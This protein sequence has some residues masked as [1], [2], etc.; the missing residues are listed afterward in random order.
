[1]HIKVRGTQVAFQARRNPGMDLKR[2]AHSYPLGECVLKVSK[3]TACFAN[4]PREGE[5]SHVYK[6][7]QK[8]RFAMF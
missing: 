4:L 8:I 2:R 6:F 3:F 1:M 5:I 7:A